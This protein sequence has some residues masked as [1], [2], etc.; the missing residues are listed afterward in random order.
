[1]SQDRQPYIRPADTNERCL[2]KFGF[3]PTEEQM[4]IVDNIG[5]G[6]DCFLITG[7]GWGKSLVSFLPLVLWEDHTI[8]IILPLHALMKGQR[9]KPERTYGSSCIALNSDQEIYDS[10]LKDLAQGKYRAVFMRPEIILNN[11]RLKDLWSLSKWRKNVKT[12]M[13]DE[14]YYVASWGRDIGK[15][16]G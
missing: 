15:A 6:Q 8:I 1:M 11:K 3:E 7:C 9:Q 2:E 12:V 5:R 10:F 4:T 16:Y 13:I 14:I